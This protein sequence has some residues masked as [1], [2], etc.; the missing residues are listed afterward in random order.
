MEK[1]SRKSFVKGALGLGAVGILAGCASSA[2]S[3]AASASSTAAPAEKKEFTF[4]DTVRWD[5]QYDVVVMGMGAAGMVAAKTA[6]D[7]GAKVVI[8]EKCEEGKA[9]GNTKVCG[10]L[11][12]YANGDKDA[13]K[14]YYTAL[15]GG[16]DIEPEIIDAISEGVAN[17]AD[18]L[19][20]E[21]GFNKDE[22]MDWT[23]VNVGGTNMGAMSPEY[24]EMPGHEK[25][26]LWT[27]H[28]G[29]SDGYL[30]QGLKQNVTDRV[31]AIDV[32]YSS[33]A[34]SLIQDPVTKTV[35]GVTVERDGKEMNIRALNGVCICTGG[36]ENDTQM[37]QDYLGLIDYAVIG[38]L[39]NT[40]DGI[41][42]AQA[43]GA[44]L[45]HMDCYEGLFGLG[46]VTYP[47][48][49][50]IP[51][52]MIATL[53]Q[54]A[55][56]TGA[57]ILVGTDGDRFVN[58]SETVRH[59]HLYENGIWEN[60]HYPNAIYLIMD[61]TQYDLA[62][63][64]GALS[65]DYKDTVLSAATIEELAEHSANTVP[66]MM[67]YIDAFFMP[68]SAGDRPDVVPDGAVNFAFLGQFAETPRD[69]IFTTEYSMRT[70]M[71]A[72]YTLCDVDRGVPEV[73]GSV[74]DVRNLL[75]AVVKLRDG[76]P[77][78]DMHLNL[79]EKLVLKKVG[80]KIQDTDIAKLLKET[81]VR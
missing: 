41:K 71:E 12:A 60:P 55:V 74:Y 69:T 58:E 43:V 49:E 54:N 24:P 18:I 75:N 77:L 66:V 78:S 79:L 19:A 51:C 1:I 76:K 11:F 46:S 39:Y 15:A 56:N 4:A 44:D 30:Y 28:A 9:G 64:E 32:W 57:A 23:G 22:Y 27:T 5:A 31:D 42:M 17:M 70:G 81:G 73:W 20:D 65:D 72:V 6:A 53:A 3:T 13:A 63:S 16:R 68:R 50:G 2:S 52:D 26:A 80:K 36:F 10:Q 29:A 35:V 37:V 25:M 61:Q 48:E 7:N 8:V 67:P 59:G 21:F 40:G 45:W 38:G 33:P 62:V 47:V 34:K 14:S